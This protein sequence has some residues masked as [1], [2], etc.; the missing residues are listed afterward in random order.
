V[1]EHVLCIGLLGKPGDHRHHGH[2]DV[3]ALG[4]RAPHR[5]R[6]LHRLVYR[7]PRVRPS[8]VVRIVRPLE[9]GVHLAV[10]L[11]TEAPAVSEDV[12]RTCVPVLRVGFRVLVGLGVVEEHAPLERRARVVDLLELDVHPGD[13]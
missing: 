4:R 12:E 1:L 9:L 6:G 8:R 7:Q 11:V 10:S 13:V 2:R 5:F 3:S